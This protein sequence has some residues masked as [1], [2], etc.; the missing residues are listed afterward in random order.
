MLMTNNNNNNQSNNNN[1]NHRQQYK[2]ITMSLR[3]SVDST[4]ASQFTIGDS[5]ADSFNA[6]KGQLNAFF[7]WY[8]GWID[9]EARA[10]VLRSEAK[11]KIIS[12]FGLDQENNPAQQAED[13]TLARIT[14]FLLSICMISTASPST[15]LLQLGREGG[16]PKRNH[17]LSILLTATSVQLKTGW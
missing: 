1:N 7:Q 4:L 2:I 10:D 9:D 8:R 6:A 17:C 3:T 14:R 13:C 16:V 11:N 12:W 5:S 15:W